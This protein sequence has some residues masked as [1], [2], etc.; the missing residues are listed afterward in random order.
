[1]RFRIALFGAAVCAVLAGP[2]LV[3]PVQAENISFSPVAKHRAAGVTIGEGPSAPG[4]G[5]A[6][7]LGRPDLAPERS[8]SRTTTAQS[9]ARPTLQPWMHGDVAAAW[10]AG[11]RGQGVTITV[12]DDFT[13]GSRSVGN[14]GTGQ[15]V[16]R[17]GEWTRL[18]AS[19]IAPSS[20]TVA[21]DFASG[22]AVAL[23]PNRLNVVNLSYGM[24]ARAGFSAAQIRWSAQENSIISHARNGSAVIAKA[25]GNDAVAVG[26]ANRSGNAD[27]LNMALVGTRSTIFVGALDRNGAVN[28]RANLAS[29]SNFA[30]SNT[31]VQRQFLTVGV[32]GDLTGLYGTSFAAPVVAGYAAVLGSKFTTATPVQITN[33]LLDTARQDTINNYNAAIH[34]RGEASL[35]RAIAPSSIR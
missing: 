5:T 33:R 32:R 3:H 8:A 28:N 35:S 22:R 11:F 2:G 13:S 26:A 16:L 23:T 24:M 15:Q 31:T 14:L 27:Y 18:E 34:G 29:Y 30:G 6:V 4:A 20:T 7:A 19:L 1:M 12:V 25:A 17:H 21:H 9:A 10:A